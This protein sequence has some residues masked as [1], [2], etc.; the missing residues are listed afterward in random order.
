M[1]DLQREIDTTT[2][3]IIWIPPGE[4]TVGKVVIHR[5]VML[6]GAGFSNT[7]LLGW[8]YVPTRASVG[9][10]RFRLSS[11][12]FNSIGFQFEYAYRATIRDCLIDKVKT[13][14]FIRAGNTTTIE[15]NYIVGDDW[16]MV[17]KNEENADEGDWRIVGNTFDSKTGVAAIHYVSGGGA[18]ILDNKILSHKYG[19][20][21]AFEGVSSDLLING[22]SIEN[23]T[24]VA[25]A[26]RVQSGSFENVIINNNQF[27]G[28]MAGITMN[29]IRRASIVGNVANVPMPFFQQV[30]CSKVEFSHVAL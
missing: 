19:I 12:A 1:F 22:N 27:A 2:S 7:R 30:G 8:F 10:E 25:I 15:N 26:L 28:N 6:M 4:H 5:P 23:Q 3:G 13:P 16:G 9:F 20:H 11:G 14:I 18:R 21:M 29:N 24:E 17:V